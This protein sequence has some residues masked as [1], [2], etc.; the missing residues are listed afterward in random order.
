MKFVKSPPDKN[1]MAWW[2]EINSDLV[3]LVLLEGCGARAT[4]TILSWNRVDWAQQTRQARARH[5]RFLD[6]TNRREEHP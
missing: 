5:P 4:A 3:K 1:N 6:A 2:Q